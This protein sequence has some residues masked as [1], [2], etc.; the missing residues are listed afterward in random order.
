MFSIRSRKHWVFQY[1]PRDRDDDFG[2]KPVGDVIAM[3][4]LG[5]LNFTVSSSPWPTSF[6]EPR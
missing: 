2:W 5:F 6:R 3:V 1:V 4:Y